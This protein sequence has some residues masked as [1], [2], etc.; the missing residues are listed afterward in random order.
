VSYNDVPYPGAAVTT[1]HPAQMSAMARL[2]GMRPAPPERCRVLELGC[3]DGANLVPMAYGL[4]GSEFIG[5]DLSV[6][7]VEAAADL[8]RQV[9]LANARFVAMDIRDM[10]TLGGPFDYI[11]CHGVFSWV[12]ADVREAIL[13]GCRDMLAPEGV[14]FVSYNAL[15][16]WHMRGIVRELMV[17]HAR[18]FT[19]PEER[20]EQ[21]RAIVQF[22]D[23]ASGRI[24]E[25]S[26]GTSAFHEHMAIERKLLESRPDYYVL[27]E[28]LEG[29]NRAFY[30]HEFVEALAPH[31]LQYLA[32]SSFSSM[33]PT[34][35][36]ADIGETL[37]S[38]APDNVRLEQYRDFLTNRL[39]RQSLICGET[40]RLERRL[41]VATL[42][43]MY[44]RLGAP[45]GPEPWPDDAAPLPGGGSLTLAAPAAKA[46]VAALR[47]A[48]PAALSYAELQ[49]AASEREGVDAANTEHFGGVLYTLFAHDAVDIRSHRP[50]M[51]TVGGAFPRASA[52]ARALAPRGESLPNL[53]HYAV[54]FD[55]FT[56]AFIP[57]VDGTRDRAALGTVVR[58]LLA[59]PGMTLQTPA[60]PVTAA[61]LGDPDVA[62][63]VDQL[64]EGMG[65]FGLLEQ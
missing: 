16:G 57:Y 38:I 46:V 64:I 50:E 13:A 25:A 5:I 26:G 12:A 22:V 4:P 30:L 32:D 62:G 51:V 24:A 47:T 36:P 17:Y 65:S 33:L 42:A 52:V 11:L 37:E 1:T 63:I 10:T 53:M 20:V 61:D 15:P 54:T 3:G 39:F 2:F 35:L 49:E 31:G 14:A 23:E 59:R 41:D 60:G 58:D 18:N 55:K 45:P 27:H 8:V 48:F 29:E 28:F 19:S 34:N 6:R 56:D 21:A 43:E 40:V 7:H 44:F 9:G